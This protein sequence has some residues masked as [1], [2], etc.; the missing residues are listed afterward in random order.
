MQPVYFRRIL[1][2]NEYPEGRL[3]SYGASYRPY[4]VVHIYEG[5][6]PTAQEALEDLYRHLEQDGIHRSTLLEPF[7]TDDR[8]F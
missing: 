6:G 3:V 7:Q 5:Q 1:H 2:S 4:G 8:H